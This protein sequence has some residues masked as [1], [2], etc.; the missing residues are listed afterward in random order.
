MKWAYVALPVALLAGALAACTSGDVM[1]GTDSYRDASPAV[2]AEAPF[3]DASLD[4]A[5]LDEAS[6]DA[7]GAGD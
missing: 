6:L 4:D 2:A 5:S 3:D 1:I 7:D